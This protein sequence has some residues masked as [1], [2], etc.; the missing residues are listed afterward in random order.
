MVEGLFLVV[1]F[2]G[3]VLVLVLV[4]GLLLLLLLHGGLLVGWVLCVWDVWGACLLV[5]CC[6]GRATRVGVMGVVA[7]GDGLDI[8][9]AGGIGTGII[10]VWRLGEVVMVMVMVMVGFLNRCVVVASHL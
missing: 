2:G 10:C 8:C 5:G 6:W 3:L 9:A 7:I 4:L 1:V